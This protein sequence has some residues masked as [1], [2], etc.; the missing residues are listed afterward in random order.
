MVELK[1]AAY[2]AVYL[3]Y[4]TLEEFF[5]LIGAVLLDEQD[6]MVYGSN[7]DAPTQFYVE[8]K[9]GFAQIFGSPVPP[10][11]AALQE[12]LLVDKG[13]APAKV[14]LYTPHLPE[15]LQSTQCDALRSERQRFILD[16][17]SDWAGNS[18]EP[19]VSDIKITTVHQG[20]VAAIESRFGVVG[21]FWRSPE[22]FIRKALAVVAW[23][24]E[25][26]AAICYAAAVADGRA[27]IDVLTLPEYRHLG[28]G[29]RVV[30]L[31]NRHCLAQGVRPLWDCF[32]NNAGSMALCEST[33]FVPSQAA[34]PFF[35]LNK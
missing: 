18:L 26:P 21:R 16:P 3:L 12:Y 9:F 14:R 5:P 2:P 23:V 10:F 17:A 29:K 28:L 13:F 22:D 15:F 34:Y 35:T 30:T 11:E 20:N 25:K 1:K 6:G 24:S 4:R 7:S 8:H 33:G 19:M 31:F 27:E 32:T